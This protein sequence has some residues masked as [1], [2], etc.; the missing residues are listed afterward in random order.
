MESPDSSEVGES[1][2]NEAPLSGELSCEVPVLCF[3]SRLISF[4]DRKVNIRES[5]IKL[6]LGKKSHS[7][8]STYELVQFPP[9]FYFPF[10]LFL[11]DIPF[12]SALDILIS[13][14]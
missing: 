9:I 14:Q 8:I 5:I 12:P 6:P 7:M 3:F 2:E 1:I 4:S 13:I 11:C 10:I